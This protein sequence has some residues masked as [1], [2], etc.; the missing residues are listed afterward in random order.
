MLLCFHQNK[1]IKVENFR[2]TRRKHLAQE[3]IITWCQL[4]WMMPAF[5]TFHIHR[6][7][8]ID[9]QRLVF[10]F[11]IAR[12]LLFLSPLTFTII[13]VKSSDYTIQQPPILL[14]IFFP[15]LALT[16][17]RKD[18]AALSSPIAGVY[19][20]HAPKLFPRE[21]V[22]AFRDSASTRARSLSRRRHQKHSQ[23]PL[24][25]FK[26][27]FAIHAIMYIKMRWGCDGSRGKQK[28]KKR[29]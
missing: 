21:F 22:R 5:K 20:F 13:E 23:N 16:K 14:F 4:K 1:H 25:N 3:C 15:F 6:T 18:D 9:S 27:S 26:C 12:C 11:H 7:K 2:H 17:C 19:L 8:P 29:M 28:K 10:A 24:L